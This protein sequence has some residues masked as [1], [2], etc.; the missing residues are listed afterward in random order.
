MIR[1]LVEYNKEEARI[2]EYQVVDL[3]AITTEGYKEANKRAWNTQDTWGKG[4]TFNT[5]PKT[6]KPT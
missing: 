4:R 3:P 6:T 5:F 2:V 1:I